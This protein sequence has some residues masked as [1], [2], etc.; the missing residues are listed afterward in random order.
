MSAAMLKR[1]S[2]VKPEFVVPPRNPKA[3]AE[4]IL[5]LAR[6][7]EQRK[8]FGDAARKRVEKEFSI[9]KCVKAH[10]DL[11]EETLQKIEARKIAA[12]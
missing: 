1:W 7:P 10:A 4:A 12:E 5:E 11:Y 9:D 6:N 3:I 2:M 8:R